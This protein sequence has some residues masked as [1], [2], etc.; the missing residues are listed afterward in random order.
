MNIVEL[1]VMVQTATKGP[2]LHWVSGDDKVMGH[3]L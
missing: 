1:K 2:S 3:V